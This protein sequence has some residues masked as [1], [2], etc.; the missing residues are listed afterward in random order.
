MNAK[1]YNGNVQPNSKEFKIWV[2][3][4]GLIKTWDGNKWIEQSGGS[5]SGSGNGVEYTYLDLRG[6]D[7]TDPDYAGLFYGLTLYAS[8]VFLKDATVLNKSFTGVLFGTT[9]AFLDLDMSSSLKAIAV[10]ENLICNLLNGEGLCSIKEQII[11]NIGE[12]AYN[13]IPRITKEQF[14]NLGA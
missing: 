5:G 12:E 9:G 1:I 11:I 3:D 6:Y 10:D 13:S 14:Y 8:C 7:A 2:N 4:E